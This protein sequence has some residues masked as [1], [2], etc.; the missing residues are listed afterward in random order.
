MIGFNTR[1]NI[2]YYRNNTLNS[3]GV[4]PPIGYGCYYYIGRWDVYT[5]LH[6]LYQ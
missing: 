6:K 5:R 1:T 2:V 4:L 3:K